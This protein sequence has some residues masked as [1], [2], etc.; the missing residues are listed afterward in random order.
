LRI[1]QIAHVGFLVVVAVLYTVLKTVLPNDD[2]GRGLIDL[3]VTIALSVWGV[4]VF[5]EALQGK[6]DGSTKERLIKAYRRLLNRPFP[7]IVSNIL[8]GSLCVSGLCIPLLFRSVEFYSV[9]SVELY[10]DRAGAEPSPV[11]TLKASE[12]AK[13]RMPI[14]T[15]RLVVYAM[16]AKDQ[17]VE[18][19]PVSAV[20]IE[21]LPIWSEMKRI[22]IPEVVPYESLR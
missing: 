4:L 11:G 16:Q 13:L 18:R 9:S 8:L 21:V 10:E 3:T 7:L 2:P 6:Q 12:P 1:G 5:V 19:K 14:G 17:S 20:R 15:R 22:E